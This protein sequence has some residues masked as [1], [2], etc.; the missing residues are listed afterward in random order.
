[1]DARR[2]AAPVGELVRG[3][4][5]LPLRASLGHFDFALSLMSITEASSVKLDWAR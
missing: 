5:R 1:M 4:S 2:A 3:S